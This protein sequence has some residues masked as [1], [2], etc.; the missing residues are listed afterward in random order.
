M[1]G[2]NGRAKTLVLIQKSENPDQYGIRRQA[3]E[4]REAV[5]RG[6]GADRFDIASPQK[7]QRVIEDVVEAVKVFG[8][9]QVASIVDDR[10]D[11]FVSLQPSQVT[12][13]A[14]R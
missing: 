3:F 1:Q 11:L 13:N 12:G 9:V 7:R 8:V 2:L 10:A 14:L 5:A 6:A 4:H